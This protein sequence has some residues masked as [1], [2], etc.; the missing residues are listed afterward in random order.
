MCLSDFD[1]QHDGDNDDMLEL[2]STFKCFRKPNKNIR[3]IIIEL[4]HQELIQKPR[5]VLNCWAPILDVLRHDHSFQTLE[6]L[7]EMYEHKRPTAKKIIKL[8]QGEPSTDAKRQSLDYL[9][10]FVKSFERKA[11]SMFVRFCTG[12]DV[13]TC[14][15]IEICFSSLEGYQRR[16]VARTCIPILDLPTSYESYPALAEEFTNIMKESQAWSFDIISKLFPYLCKM[17]S[18]FFVKKQR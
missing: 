18:I 1:P 2:L 16:P 11:L 12:S 10:K 9:K 8:F 15:S 17:S 6:G 7:D 3:S 5:Y 14:D 4:A 13:I